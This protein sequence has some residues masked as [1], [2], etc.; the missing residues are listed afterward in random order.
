MLDTTSPV[1]LIPARMGVR[2]DP[3]LGQGLPIQMMNQ[4]YIEAVQA[5][6]GAPLLVP[7][8]KVTQG[9]FEWVDGLLLPGG[10]DVDPTRYGATPHPTSQWDPLLD[11]LEFQLLDM[12]RA[13]QVPILGICRGLQ[14]INVALGGTLYQDLPSQRPSQLEHPRHGPRDRLVHELRVDRES[15]LGG[16]LNGDRFMVNSLHHQGIDRLGRGLVASARSEDGL[17][18][19]IETVSGPFLIG[20]Q[21]HPEELAPGYEFARRL[22]TAFVGECR[23]TKAQRTLGSAE[24]AVPI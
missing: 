18:E 20:V 10:E 12:A 11:D 23:Q 24:V 2:D 13:G 21:F 6:G 22:F 7:L 5:A 4:A 19:G 9:L 1:I 16:V 8:G 14:V 15:Q 17:I 3:D